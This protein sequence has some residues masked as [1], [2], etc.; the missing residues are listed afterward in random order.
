MADQPNGLARKTRADK[1]VPRRS[2]MDPWY[3]T[4]MALTPEQQRAS[5]DV[6]EALHRQIMRGKIVAPEAPGDVDN[7]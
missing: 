6:L 7:G 1:G 2:T 4:F 3:D 5:I